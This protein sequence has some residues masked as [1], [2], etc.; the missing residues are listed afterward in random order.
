MSQ[1]REELLRLAARTK[2]A[3]LKELC[4]RQP[5]FWLTNFVKTFDEHDKVQAV[6]PFP[7]KP[8]VEMICKE[9]ESETILHIA[10]SRQMT[11]SWLAVA[12]LLHEAQFY[13]YR[14]QAVFSKKELD[15]LNLVERAKFMYNYQPLWLKNLVPLD[16]KMRDMPLGNLYFANGSKMV[17]FAQGKD[18]IRSYVPSTALLDEAAFQ[19]KLEETYGAC[20]PCCQKIVSVSSAN[21]GYFQR[22]C[23]LENK[24][25]TLTR[26]KD[27]HRVIKL[28]Y[29][30]DP[31]K[32]AAWVEKESAKIPGGTSSL[33]WRRE[34]EIDFGAGSGELV[35]PEFYDME[36]EIVCDPFKLNDTYNFFGGFDWGVRNPTS[37]HV[38]AEAQDGTCYSVW[39]YYNVGQTVGAVARAIRECPFYDRLQWIAA[40][41]SIWTEN[42]GR[43]DGFTSVAA[44]MNDED[45][46]GPYIIDKLMPAHDRS[47]V[48]GVAKF[49]AM[50]GQ[51]PAKFKIFRNC[52]NQINEFKNLKYPERKERTNETEKLL[53][54][55]NHTWDDAKYFVLSHPAGQVA[56]E[57]PKFGTIRYLNSITETAV[58]MAKMTGRTVQEEFNDLYGTRA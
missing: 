37:F 4:K 26:N 32:N 40:D 22:L 9:W 7:I 24:V 25:E 50:W 18:Q 57:R 31:E 58:E 46:V 48:G 1:D 16:R 55:N 42:Q 14:L 30:A 53:D 44:M 56:E 17:G 6:K 20:V 49:K 39:E 11:V 33:M 29:S 38:Y 21:P 45:E 54:K 51:V 35:F 43:K 12:L 27:G 52:V 10:K 3:A 41:P 34:M 28:H 47:D 2:A 36:D 19:D 23:D 8:Y 15:A 5:I 13:G